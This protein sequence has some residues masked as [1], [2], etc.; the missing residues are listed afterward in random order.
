MANWY[1]R[2]LGEM[3]ALLD[4]AEAGGAS[5]LHQATVTLT[6]AQMIAL[7]PYPGFP[8][9]A[10]PGANKMLLFERAVLVTHIVT[11]L[12]WTDPTGDDPLLFVI[13]PAVVDVDGEN[14]LRLS[15][16]LAFNQKTHQ[17]YG[18]GLLSFFAVDTVGIAGLRVLGASDN[19][20]AEHF[21]RM[22]QLNARTVNAPFHLLLDTAFDEPV[23]DP[24]NTLTVT[25]FY[26]ILNL[27][28]GLF[29]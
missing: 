6:N 16:L 11:P 12:A 18:V 29:E 10:A 5:L 26:Y 24:A 2:S 21:G 27:T 7:N 28:T 8:I 14:Y 13:M 17:A 4:A 3:D 1:G 19:D 15:E 20:D 25:T 9:V 23:G 22:F